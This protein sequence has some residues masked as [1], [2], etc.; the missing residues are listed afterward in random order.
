MEREFDVVIIGSG[1]AARA[2][3]YPVLALRS[4]KPKKLYGLAEET[5]EGKDLQTQAPQAHEGESPQEAFALQGVSLCSLG[6]IVRRLR[7]IPAQVEFVE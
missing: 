1:S 3:A 7:T 5:P 2:V 6:L 4:G